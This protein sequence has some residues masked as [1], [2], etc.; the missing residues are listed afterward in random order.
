MRSTEKK[1]LK[2]KRKK[3]DRIEK[4]LSF[5]TEW[6]CIERIKMIESV[7]NTRSYEGNRRKDCRTLTT[8]M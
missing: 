5:K 4:K 8:A 1:V 6:N 3:K 2:E 7:L